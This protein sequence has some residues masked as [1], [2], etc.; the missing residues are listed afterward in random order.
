MTGTA[1]NECK[2]DP[3]WG[4]EVDSE[5]CKLCHYSWLL[6]YKYIK[7]FKSSRATTDYNSCSLGNN[8]FY[9]E[10]CDPTKHRFLLTGTGP[11]ECTCDPGWGDEVDSEDCKPCHYS[12][13]IKIN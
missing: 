13:L 7:L 6:V 2:C 5:D 3:G 4:D 10:K 9:C 12:W 11:N 8:K 1:P